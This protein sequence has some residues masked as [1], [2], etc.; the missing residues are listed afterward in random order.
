MNST[1]NHFNNIAEKYDQFKKR[2]SLYYQ[3][4]KNAIRKEITIKKARILDI[5]CATGSILNFL[6]PTNG[7]GIDLSF[8]MIKIARKKYASN[9][10]LSFAVFD[11]EKRPYKKSEFDYILFN[12]VIE[13]VSNQEQV[14]SNISKSMASDTTLILSM[15]NPL[16]EP[17]LLLLE[18]L[19]FKMPEGPHNRISEN[20]L[21]FFIGQNNLYIVSRKVYFLGL[22]YVYAIKKRA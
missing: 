8:E 21:N 22:I 13:H 2:N 18:K 4:L 15:A 19:H 16:W 7:V 1:A 11:I 20:E 12:D 17:I 6:N 5:G 3:T 9:K 10:R 14:I